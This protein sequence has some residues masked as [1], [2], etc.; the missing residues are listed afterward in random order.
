MANYNIYLSTE[1][2][3]Y[4]FLNLARLAGAS[5]LGVSGCGPGY[6]IQIEATAAQ[7]EYINKNIYTAEIHAYTAAQAWQAWKA[8]RLTV[9]QLA[10][11]QQ[12]HG[13][14][15]TPAGSIQEAGI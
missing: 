3:K 5:V 9:G 8:G 6:Y 1:N 12:Q 10:E 2:E 4:S 13:I 7:V 14:Y 15:F 11:W